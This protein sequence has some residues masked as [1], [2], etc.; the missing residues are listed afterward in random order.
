MVPT[1]PMTPTRPERRRPHGG[2][3]AGLDHAD[4]GNVELLVEGVERGGGR[5]V[6]GDDERLHVVLEQHV[7]DLERVFQHL[8]A[9]LGAVGEPAGVAEVDDALVGQQVDERAQHREPSEPGVEHADRTRG[10]D[11]PPSRP[12]P[13]GG[14]PEPVGHRGADPDFR[15]R[16]RDHHVE[17]FGRRLRAGVGRANARTRRHR[18]ANRR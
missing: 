1:V 9:R 4:D 10:H 3:Q 8:V 5:A 7:G 17:A 12:R 11:A 15:G 6:A 13:A 14:A 18:P 2:A 16:D